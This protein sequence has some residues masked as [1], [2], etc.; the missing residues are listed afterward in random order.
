MDWEELS[1]LQQM[2]MHEDAVVMVSPAPVFGVKLVE[3]VQRVFTYFGH[4]LVV[5]AE[6]WM[7]HPGSANVMLNIFRHRR[8][9]RHFVIL[10]GDVH[11]SFVY[12]VKIR[13]RTNSP[14]IWQITASGFRNAFPRRLLY[15]FD[16]LNRWLFGSASPLNWFTRRRRMKLRARRPDGDRHRRL[17][18]GSALGRVRLDATG[19][20]T[21]I[22]LLLAEGGEVRFL[23]P[24]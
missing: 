14:A 7:A 15:W 3:A 22:S 8:T 1:D 2:L 6:N 20:P 17:V 24:R 18:N 19:A 21:E 10:S 9:P 23:E 4:A 13:Y 5:D 12:D 11:Y 16:L